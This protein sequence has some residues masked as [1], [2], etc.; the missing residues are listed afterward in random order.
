M[1]TDMKEVFANAW[2]DSER[3]YSGSIFFHVHV[4]LDAAAVDVVEGAFWMYHVMSSL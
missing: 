1:C 2:N 4:E 3:R